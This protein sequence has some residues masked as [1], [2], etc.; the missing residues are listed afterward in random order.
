MSALYSH[1]YP[2]EKQQNKCNIVQKHMEKL[3]FELKSILNLIQLKVFVYGSST[4]TLIHEHL[5]N[6]L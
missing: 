2:L 5:I 3:L 1:L 6:T 4:K